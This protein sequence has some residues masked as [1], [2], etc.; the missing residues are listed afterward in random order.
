MG[1]STK[2]REMDSERRNKLQEIVN[3]S[4]HFPEIEEISSK[5]AGELASNGDGTVIFVDCR[6]KAE[7]FV[8]AIP[9]AVHYEAFEKMIANQDELIVKTDQVCCYCTIGVRSGKYAKWLRNH[10][11]SLEG[12]KIINMKGSILEWSYEPNC[13]KLVKPENDAVAKGDVATQI[14]CFGE[15]WNLAPVNYEPVMFNMFE[16]GAQA[17]KWAFY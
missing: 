2:G 6:S 7:W 16:Q 9:N 13:P 12:K 10:S 15:R 11:K 1:D 14:H 5:Q 3:K 4:V 17:A 8:S